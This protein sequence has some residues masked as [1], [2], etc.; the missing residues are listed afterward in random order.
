[1]HACMELSEKTDCEGKKKLW[2]EM[3]EVEGR[4]KIYISLKNICFLPVHN[5]NA[6]S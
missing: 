4:I 6:S 5:F 1:M 3:N 2:R